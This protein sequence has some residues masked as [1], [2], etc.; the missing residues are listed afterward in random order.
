MPTP[1]STSSYSTANWVALVD[2]FGYELVL[3]IEVSGAATVLKLWIK[4]LVEITIATTIIINPI[5]LML[6]NWLC[7][8]SAS[9]TN[10]DYTFPEL[11]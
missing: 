11:Q 7:F 10:P 9:I 2:E 6:A 4:L 3:S 5:N 1:S 8:V